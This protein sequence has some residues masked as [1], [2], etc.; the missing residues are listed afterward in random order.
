MRLLQH[1]PATGILADKKGNAFWLEGGAEQVVVNPADM[2]KQFASKRQRTN[3]PTEAGDIDVSL[4]GV[5]E[6]QSNWR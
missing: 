2:H 6:L 1:S 4:V 3:W 5:P